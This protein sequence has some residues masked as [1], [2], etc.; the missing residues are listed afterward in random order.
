MQDN[1]RILKCG[2]AMMCNKAKAIQLLYGKLG[3]EK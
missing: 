3:Q 1:L 2:S